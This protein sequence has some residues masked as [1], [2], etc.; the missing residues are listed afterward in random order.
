MNFWKF[1]WR[2]VGPGKWFGKVLEVGWGG[3]YWR[4][5]LRLMQEYESKRDQGER[6]PYDTMPEKHGIRGINLE[7]SG[8][9][10][11]V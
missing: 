1:W 7:G 4:S 10:L 5:G 2:E 9:W 6:E 11:S 8:V 3:L